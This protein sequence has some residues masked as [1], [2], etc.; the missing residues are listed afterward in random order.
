MAEINMNNFATVEGVLETIE[1]RT[2]AWN[3]AKTGQKKEAISARLRVKAGEEQSV[4]VSLFVNKTNKDGSVSK[5]YASLEEFLT[6]AKSIAD[7]GLDDASLVR[8]SYGRFGMEE[9]FNQSGSL[10]SFPTVNASFV[11]VVSQNNN[12]GAEGTVDLAVVDVT[13]D[14]DKEGIETGT[15]TLKGVYTDGY[16]AELIELKAI[17]PKIVRGIQQYIEIGKTYA[18]YIKGN[19]SAVTTTETVESL[20]GD[21][22]ERTFTRRVS[23]FIIQS[24]LEPQGELTEEQ[25]NEA[26]ALRKAGLDKMKARQEQRAN[27]TKKE[28]NVKASKK[29]DYDFGF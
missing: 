22:V 21:P 2:V 4:P 28:E 26:L 11:N 5:V 24:V 12:P 27:N 25:V 16:R 1:T 9:Y 7:V 13:N 10:T 15:L 29:S 17:D 20:I 3:D 8:T 23:Q 14:V 6:K 19:F 18:F